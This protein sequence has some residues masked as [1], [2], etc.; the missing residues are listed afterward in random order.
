M[1]TVL[2]ALDVGG[3]A[4]HERGEQPGQLRA[5]ASRSGSTGASAAGSRCCMRG[6]VA[7]AQALD[8]DRGDHARDDRDGRREHLREG[9]DQRR[10]PRGRQA[11]GAAARAGPRRSSSSSSRRTARSP[12]PKTIAIQFAPIGLVA[13][14]DPQAL[15]G[16][17][18][19]ARRACSSDRVGQPVPAAER[20]QADDRHGHDRGDDDEELQHLVVDRRRQPA[21]RDVDEH[22]ARRRRR[23]RARIGQPSSSWSTS[24]SA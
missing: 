5:R 24:A 9:A 21:E 3:D 11:P 20:L 22:D 13:C 2:K 6:R 10:A 4:R 14:R 12:S 19:L 15:P 23:C 1:T 7:A 17:G 18:R 16:V 8:R